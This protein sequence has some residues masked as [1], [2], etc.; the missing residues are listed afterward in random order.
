MG[1]VQPHT[2]QKTHKLP[3]EDSYLQ[4]SIYIRT[5]CSKGSISNSHIKGHMKSHDNKNMNHCALC[6]RKFMS[7]NHLNIDIKRNTEREFI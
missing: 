7:R 2:H 4:K 1:Y 5:L 6:G 3:H